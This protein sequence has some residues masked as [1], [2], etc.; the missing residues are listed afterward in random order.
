MC[1]S[2]IW[3]AMGNKITNLKSKN[4]NLKPPIAVQSDSENNNISRQEDCKDG[5]NTLP[6]PE[7]FCLNGLNSKYKTYALILYDVFTNEECEQ[8]IKR[9]ENIGKTTIHKRRD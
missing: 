3:L 7:D 6:L 9:T 5:E 4:G 1:I 8:L 2:T